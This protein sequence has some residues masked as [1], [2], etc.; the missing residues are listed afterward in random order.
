[1][2]L[3]L[4]CDQVFAVPFLTRV[5]DVKAIESVGGNRDGDAGGCVAEV[6]YDDEEV[7]VCFAEEGVLTMLIHALVVVG[8]HDVEEQAFT[9]GLLG[10]AEVEDFG[11]ETLKVL[12][13]SGKECAVK[14]VVVAPAANEVDCPIVEDGGASI[15]SDEALAVHSSLA[16]FLTEVDHHGTGAHEG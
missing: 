5:A 8:I 14:L 12:F 9:Y 7:V 4:A 2:F 13:F 10:V 11:V 16:Q 6:G 1:V 15:H 3:F